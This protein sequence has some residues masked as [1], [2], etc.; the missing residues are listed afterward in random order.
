MTDNSD[1]HVGS[2][3]ANGEIVAIVNKKKRRIVIGASI[4]RT[5][6]DVVRTIGTRNF[7]TDEEV[8][9]FLFT[10]MRETIPIDIEIDEDGFVTGHFHAPLSE[11]E[12]K[13]GLLAAVPIEKLL[14]TKK[15]VRNMILP[16][17][18]MVPSAIFNEQEDVRVI[19]DFVVTEKTINFMP[20]NEKITAVFPEG[21]SLP[22]HGG[23]ISEDNPTLKVFDQVGQ[24][25]LP[26]YFL[27]DVERCTIEDFFAD[28]KKKKITIDL[29]N[30]NHKFKFFSAFESVKV[31][32][33]HAMPHDVYSEWFEWS[34]INYSIILDWG[35]SLI[36]ELEFDF[37]SKLPMG[38]INFND[39]KL[40]ER[41]TIRGAVFDGMSISR[42]E[43][44]KHFKFTNGHIDSCEFV[45]PSSLHTVHMEMN[46]DET[47]VFKN[48]LG[49]CCV[50]LSSL[51]NNCSSV[52]MRNVTIIDADESIKA[53]TKHNP[54]I[55]LDIE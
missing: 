19:G 46:N 6:L 29:V 31:T 40:L 2:K 53:L 13:N 7:N 1:I 43:N 32:H 4:L 41:L 15:E 33:C 51:N 11:M 35:E 39:L 42:N 48:K 21:S 14:P 45:L 9:C 55:Q 38:P 5:V 52:M 10:C 17:R 16:E 22:R 54:D 27:R 20:L 30:L 50:D 44:I 12:K 47:D 23:R 49:P 25:D 36:K 28:I 37:Q 24:V 8:T 34:I 18:F 26:R 3:R